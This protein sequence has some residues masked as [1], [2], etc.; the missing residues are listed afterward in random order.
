MLEKKGASSS[1]Q[2][3]AAILSLSFS[4]TYMVI[5]FTPLDLYLHNPT[6]FIVGWKFFAPALF[7]VA[8]VCS[9]ALSVVLFMMW[10]K[11]TMLGV[12]LFLLCALFFTFI[13][14][15]YQQFL[16]MYIYIVSL[17]ACVIVI[18][19]L[20]TRLLREKA[21]DAALLV[22][23]GVYVISYIQMLFL[24]GDMALITGDRAEYGEQIINML[25]WVIISFMPLCLW[26]I[27]KINSKAFHYEKALIFTAFLISG[28]Q[29]AGLVSSAVFADLPAGFDNDLDKKFFSYESAVHF[30]PEEN[31]CVFLLDRLDTSYMTEVLENYP[32]LYG[33]LDGFTLYQNNIA[34]FFGT[35][36]SVTTI[37][38]QHHY[39]EGLTF[40]EYWEEAWAQHTM[41][42]SL[43]EAGYT[44]NLF[45]DV[46]STYGDVG[47]IQDKTDN[48]KSVEI[49]IYL[50]GMLNAAGRLSLSRLSP[51]F[52]KNFF[53]GPIDSAFGN[54][55][56][57]LSAADSKVVQQPSVN[58]TSDLNFYEYIRHSDF[59]ANSEAKVFNFIHLNCS[60]ADWDKTVTT[61]GYHYDTKNGIIKLGGNYIDSTRACFE[62]L[63]VYFEK[64]RNTGVYDNSTIILLADHGATNPYNAKAAVTTCLFIKPRGESGPLAFDTESELSNQYFGTTMLEAAG[65]PK[66]KPEVSYFDIIGGALPPVRH[67][68]SYSNWWGARG[69]AK[70]IKLNGIYEIKGD[71]S[72]YKNWDFKGANP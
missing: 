50:K 26:I 70:M 30:N 14:F 69:G 68:Y 33:Q 19:I 27:F 7:G 56:F 59:S 65:L 16:S 55:F 3:L 18:W 15:A 64:M 66:T 42:D 17:I 9:I 25:L 45:I 12:A 31:I 21:V 40:E 5:L 44:T 54:D 51:Y 6:D 35:F 38:T 29:I 52:M 8:L 60:H 22:L 49:G 28:M 34:E 13:R 20:L 47:Q 4:A 72:D 43:R 48:L 61:G 71:A 58:A 37:L 53:L 2:K 62:I 67:F 46:L 36:P 23:W 39:R 32:E 41:I 1:R 24:N 63:N 57:R 10:Y 11:K